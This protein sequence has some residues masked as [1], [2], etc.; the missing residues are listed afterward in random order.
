MTKK[1]YKQ[2]EFSFHYYEPLLAEVMDKRLKDVSPERREA[3]AQEMA[4][5]IHP[6]NSRFKYKEI[7]HELN[8]FDEGG[9]D[10]E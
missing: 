8:N 5:A 1:T 9:S 3:I 4:W 2:L 7:P 6:D 10:A